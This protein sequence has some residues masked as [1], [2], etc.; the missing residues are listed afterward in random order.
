MKKIVKLIKITL[1]FK[2]TKKYN[3]LFVSRFYSPVNPMGSC[4]AWS[5]YL[6]T[7]LLGR[8]N[9]VI[10]INLH[11]RMLPTSAGVEPAT[12]WSCSPVGQGIQLSHG[13][14]QYN[15]LDPIYTENSLNYS[16][17]PCNNNNNKKSD[18]PYLIFFRPKPETHI[19]VCRKYI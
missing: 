18:L 1:L 6:T 10:T 7:R 11:E 16:V 15:D 17:Q 19:F 5:V 12:S 14:Q 2:K 3:D 4:P 13:G 8:L 9:P